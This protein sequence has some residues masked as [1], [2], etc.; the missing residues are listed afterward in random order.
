MTVPLLGA[1]FRSLKPSATVEMTDRVRAARAQGRD[2]IGMSSGDPNLATDDRIIDAAYSALRNGATHYTASCGELPL[3]EAVA[4]REWSRAKAAYDADDIIVTPGGKFAVL[5]AL[6]AIVDPGEE[7]LLPQPGWV[8]YGPC[9]RLCGGV[10]VAVDMLDRFDVDALERAMTDKTRAVIV[11]SPVNPTGRVLPRADVERL[12]ELADARNIW[13][14]FDQVYADLTYDGGVAF[15]QSSDVG[16]RRTLVVD[17]LSKSFGMTGWRLGYLAMPPGIAKSVV[18]F[19][20]HSIYC[21]PA[22]I[23]AA[24]V[25]ALELSEELLPQYRAFFQGRVTRAAKV[26]DNVSGI[27]CPTPAAG[28]FLFPRVDGDETVIARRWLDDLNIAVLPGTVFGSAGAGH[29]RISLSCSDADIDRA[30]ER[31]TQAAVLA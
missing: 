21:V 8:S 11:N 16:Q 30:L 1:R 6:M 18:K 28:F 23:Q 12:V 31:I 25:R 3:R 7:V 2:I 9:V 22:F 24:G 27:S 14:I 5:A 20:Q 10:P 4:R 29:L 17:S 15:P 19:I 13:I 26:F